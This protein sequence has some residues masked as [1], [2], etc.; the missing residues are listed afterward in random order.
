MGATLSY[1]KSVVFWQYDVF[2]SVLS[3]SE[4]S[5]H[6]LSTVLRWSGTTLSVVGKLENWRSVEE[7][8]T[9]DDQHNAPRLVRLAAVAFG[10]Y[11]GIMCHS[12][13]DNYWEGNTSR[14]LCSLLYLVKPKTSQGLFLIVFLGI[15]PVLSLFLVMLWRWLPK[16]KGADEESG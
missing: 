3:S 12:F 14:T 13:E 9:E 16:S 7:W 11:D 2:H 6:T 5:E 4:R 8:D 10:G 1:E 15:I